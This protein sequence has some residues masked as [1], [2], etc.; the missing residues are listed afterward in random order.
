M[1]YFNMKSNWGVETIDQLDPKDY[2]TG[3]EFRAELRRLTYE[4]QISG[5]PV[6]VSSRC[7]KEWSEQ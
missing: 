5:N 7:T 6:Y 4:Y 3:K 1:K 2:K